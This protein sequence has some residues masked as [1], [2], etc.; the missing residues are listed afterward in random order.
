M[1][2]ATTK[3]AMASCVRLCVYV[4]KVYPQPNWNLPEPQTPP[5][6]PPLGQLH[7][8]R[9]HAH[10]PFQAAASRIEIGIPVFA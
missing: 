3:Q 4:C 8:A 10:F 6:P 1:R 7:L 5:P 9:D 2:N